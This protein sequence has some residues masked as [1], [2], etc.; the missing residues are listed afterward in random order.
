[1]ILTINCGSSSLKY[2]LFSEK[3]EYITKG[4]REDIKDH[5]KAIEEIIHEL[6]EE[7]KN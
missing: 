2:A 7:Q 5:E 1:M 4:Y 6:T 3:L